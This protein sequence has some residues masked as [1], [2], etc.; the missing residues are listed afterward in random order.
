MMQKKPWPKNVL[1]L[2]IFHN[3]WIIFGFP[4]NKYSQTNTTAVDPQHLKV[5]VA[6]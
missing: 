1:Y 6:E 5:E 4:Q 3:T 2:T